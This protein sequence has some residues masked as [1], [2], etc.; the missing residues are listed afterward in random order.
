MCNFKEWAFEIS[1]CWKCFGIRK[2]WRLKNNFF[3]LYSGK[4]SVKNTEIYGKNEFVIWFE[5]TYWSKS[6]QLGLENFFAHLCTSNFNQHIPNILKTFHWSFWSRLF[7]FYP[8]SVHSFRNFW[9]LFIE[10]KS[11]IHKKSRVERWDDGGK[12]YENNM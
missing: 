2:C 8:D 9:V 7:A 10:C 11:N 1:F 4:Q 3:A 12:I 6:V 5:K